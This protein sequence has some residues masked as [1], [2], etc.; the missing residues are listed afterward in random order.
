MKTSAARVAPLFALFALVHGAALA[1]RFDWVA[2]QLPRWFAAATLLAQF[3]LLLLASYF[4]ASVDHG[5]QAGPLWMRIRS[6]PIKLA[7]TLAFTYLAVV[8]L[9]TW[10][11]SIGPVDPTPPASFSLAQRAQWFAIMTVGMFFPNYLAASGLLIPGLRILTRP[12]RQLPLAVGLLL[13]LLVGGAFGVGAV[14]LVSSSRL[15]D[16]LEQLQAALAST[17]L[18]VVGVTLAIVLVPTVLGLVR[19]GRGPAAKG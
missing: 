4:E 14:V 1:S 11:I 5:G 17:P 13:A 8:V 3:P 10:D 16:A 12:L 18:T 7:F 2:D 15:S 9:Q 6:R 19:K